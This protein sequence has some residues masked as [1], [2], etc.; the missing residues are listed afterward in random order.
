LFQT[1]LPIAPKRYAPFIMQKR[2]NIFIFHIFLLFIGCSPLTHTNLLKIPSQEYI[3]DNNTLKTDGYFFCER[4]R[5]A[6]CKYLSGITSGLIADPQ[7]KYSEKYISAFV[8]Y[9]DGY[10][11]YS[12]NLITSSVKK[13]SEK[14]ATDYCNIVNENNKF[15][16]ARTNFENN[17]IKKAIGNNIMQDKGVFTIKN[18]SVKFQI[19]QSG[20]P[21]LFLAE[22]QGKIINDTTFTIVKKIFY[23][24]SRPENQAL[25]TYHFKKFKIKPDSA[26][27]IRN[28]RQKL[29]K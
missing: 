7:S 21:I 5:E 12:G 6:Y 14:S 13:N 25:E 9:K 22:Y 23:D 1:F 2:I 16:N 29:S 8:L 11:Y 10:A 27:Y 17:L 18:D 28:N 15:E 20:G 4:E 24:K 19:Y 3:L 26:S